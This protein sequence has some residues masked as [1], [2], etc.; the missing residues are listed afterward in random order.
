MATASTDLAP[1]RAMF[2]TS[3]PEWRALEAHAAQLRPIHLRSL[4]S[5]DPT[6]GER[7]V[8][9]GAGL[10][11]DFS[12]HRITAETIRLFTDLARAVRLPERID[13][14]F[15]GDRI[16]VTENRAVLHVALRAP[17]G[18]SIIVDERNVVEDVHAVL[19]RMAAFAERVRS[20]AWTG[21]TGKRIRKYCSRRS[22]LYTPSRD[23]VI[24]PISRHRSARPNSA[25]SSICM[26]VAYA[27]PT[28]DPADV[29]AM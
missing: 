24:R 19:D 16:N 5:D 10:Y 15:R 23:I 29:P 21:F 3:L 26:P 12:K 4:F 27:P 22:L 25:I 17:R 9:E 6:R 20:G 8:A 28:I 7:F 13:A 2:L 11:V 1:A 18:A 14:M